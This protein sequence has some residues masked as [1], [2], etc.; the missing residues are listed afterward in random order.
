MGNGREVNSHLAP[1]ERTCLLMKPSG[2]TAGLRGRIAN[3]TYKQMF[4]GG[5]T[6]FAGILLCAACPSFLAAQESNAA[7]YAAM[8]GNPKLRLVQTNF[9]GDVISIIDP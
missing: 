7:V 8:K 3:M 1:D 5:L 6:G 9:A 2:G 4:L